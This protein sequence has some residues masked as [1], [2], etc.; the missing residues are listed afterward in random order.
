[1]IDTQKRNTR[2]NAW[3]KENADR[4][5][6]VMPKGYKAVINET[7][8]RMGISAS[9]FI[10]GAITDRLQQNGVDVRNIASLHPDSDMA[11]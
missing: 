10:R 1:M 4:I 3:Q 2:Q 9:E 7:A 5:N 6:F 11:E 8:K